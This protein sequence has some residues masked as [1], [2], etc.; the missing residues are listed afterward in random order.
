MVASRLQVQ[1]VRNYSSQ[2]RLR[3]WQLLNSARGFDM[4]TSCGLRYISSFFAD[5][6]HLSLLTGSF[7]GRKLLQCLSFPG[8]EMKLNTYLTPLKQWKSFGESL[9]LEAATVR[10]EE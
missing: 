7:H 6:M 3:R 10:H 8:C 5:H 1:R 9:K 4:S 2:T